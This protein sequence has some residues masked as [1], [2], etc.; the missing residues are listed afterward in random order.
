[1]PRKPNT[2]GEH[3]NDPFPTRL[4]ELIKDN[5][6]TQEELTAVLNVKTR[7]SVTGYIDGST[8]PTIDKVVALAD[9]FNVSVDYLL[10]RTEPKTADKNLRFV[11]EYTGLKEKTIEA[12]IN[13][14]ELYRDA[15]NTL[16]LTK[17]FERLLSKLLRA[18]DEAFG[19]GYHL[20]LAEKAIV[21]DN[22]ID[23]H[24]ET[25]RMLSIL[26]DGNLLMRYAALEFTEIAAELLEE[27]SSHKALSKKVDEVFARYN[28]GR[29]YNG[30]YQE[31]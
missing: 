17:S 3:Y 18:R 4:R 7:Q 16:F 2:T 30:E 8:L 29:G 6:T 25:T 19:V 10:G 24:E 15:I 13:K 14:P 26:R 5:N 1:M 20:K 22:L 23:I 11:C 9:F 31:D 28:S 21:P 27:V 12:I